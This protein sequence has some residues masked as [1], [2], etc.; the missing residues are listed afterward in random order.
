M[1]L[2]L[3]YEEYLSKLPSEWHPNYT[4]KAMAV[5]VFVDSMLNPT[6]GLPVIIVM[7]YSGIRYMLLLENAEC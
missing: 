4:T 5:K 1:S 7:A 2:Q 6:N 3:A